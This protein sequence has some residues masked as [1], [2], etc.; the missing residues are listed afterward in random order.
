MC[1]F[2]PLSTSGQRDAAPAAV[3]DQLDVEDPASVGLRATSSTRSNR[4]VSQCMTV[5][6]GSRTAIDDLLSMCMQLRRVAQGRG[7]A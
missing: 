3:L 2:S 5:S 4:P 7:L 6:V 1:V